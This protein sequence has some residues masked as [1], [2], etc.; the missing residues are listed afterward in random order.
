MLQTIAL[1]VAGG[2][3]RCLLPKMRFAFRHP[4]CTHPCLGPS[5]VLHP[6]L[7]HHSSHSPNDPSIPPSVL[8][9]IPLSFHPFIH[10]SS[11]RST[12][13]SSHPSNHAPIHP[14]THPFT[15]PHS[16]LFITSSLYAPIHNATMNVHFYAVHLTCFQPEQLIGDRTYFLNC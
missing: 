15:Q 3:A 14:A 10:Q 7:L 6:R 4:R 9:S 1:W 16:N 5:F 13:P 11:H 8:S 2:C 12:D